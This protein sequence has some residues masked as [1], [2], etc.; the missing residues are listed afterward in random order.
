MKIS[1]KS[2]YAVRLLVEIAHNVD[3]VPIS[4][5]SERQN[6]SE[7]YLEQIIVK[8]VKAGF[9]IQSARAERGLQARETR[10]RNNFVRNF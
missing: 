6:I 3:F 4:S 5:I 9:L 8:F 10:K 1:A 2:R 7:K